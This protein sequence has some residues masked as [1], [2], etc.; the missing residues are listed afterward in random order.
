MQFVSRD[1]LCSGIMFAVNGSTPIERKL[2]EAL[3]ECDRL[4][5][6]NRQLRDRLGMPI[7][8]KPAQ[9]NSAPST[10]GSS[11]INSKSS[12]EEK[13]KFFRSLFRGREDV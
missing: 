12:S 9:P 13:V 4:R 8:K 2:A 1:R 11:A 7:E 5:E 6:E 3:T 10:T